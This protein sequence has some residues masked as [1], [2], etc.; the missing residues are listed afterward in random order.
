MPQTLQLKGRVIIG[1]SSISNIN[2]HK[3]HLGSNV[4][5]PTVSRYLSADQETLSAIKQVDLRV[6]FNILQ[7]LGLSSDDVLN[8]RLGD[9]FEVRPLSEEKEHAE[10]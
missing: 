1:L 3:V 9:L 7:A 5:W 6:V 8:L 4:S 2:P 10:A